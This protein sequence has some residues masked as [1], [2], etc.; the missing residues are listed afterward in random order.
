MSESFLPDRWKEL[1]PLLDAALERE[2]HE[3]PAFL[4][5]AC[6]GDTALRVELETLIA[7]CA[8]ADRLFASGAVERFAALLAEP[9][10]GLPKI[11]ADRYRVGREIGGGGMATVYL[12]R[13]LKHDRDVALKVLR[14]DISAVI[15]AER[16]LAE[17]RITAKLD[18]PHIL[19]LI[20]SGEADGMLF[21]TLPYVRGESLRAKLER[22][23]QLSIEDAVSIARQVASALD[24]AHAQGVVHRD[25]KP[26]NILLHEGVAM[27]ADFGIALAVEEAGGSRLT[28]TGLSLGTPQYMSPEQATGDRALDGRSDIYSLAAV[29]YEMIAGEPPVT[30]ATKQ[31]IIAK[32]LTEPPTKLRVIRSAVPE[33]VDLAVAKALSKV[34]ADRFATAGAFAHALDAA[35]TAT[36]AAPARRW[37]KRPMLAAVGVAAG[38]AVVALA[39]SY[40]HGTIGRGPRGGVTL[41]ARRQITFNGQVAIPAISGD[42]KTLAYRTTNCGPSGCTFGIELQDVVGAASQRLFDGASNI[43]SIEWSPDRRNFLFAGTINPRF[44]T[45][46]IS[47]LG[48]TPRR[49][50]SGSTFFA[51]GDSLLSVRGPGAAKNTN[52]VLVSGLD[53]VPRDSILVVTD[54]AVALKFVRA[55]P[56]SKWIVLGMY[57]RTLLEPR[58]I[59]RDGRVASRVLVG[60]VGSIPQV[61]VS[62][63]AL[64]VSPGGP[65]YPKRVVLRVAL[66]AA[67][68]QLSSTVD[69]LYTGVHTDFGVTADGAALV[70]DEGSAAFDLWGLELSEALHGVF[71]EQK[72]LVHSTSEIYVRLSPDGGRVVVGHDAG[73]AADGLLSWFTIPFGGRV[74]TPLV[75]AGKTTET[76]WSDNSTVA[77]RDRIPGPGARLA[78]SDVA[79]GAVRDPLVVPD[80][81]PRTYSHLSSG[82]WVWVSANMPELSVQFRGEAAPRR[83]RLP[84]W[85]RDA[86]DID[87]ARD[88]RHVAF[89]GWS[90]PYQDSTGVSVMSLADST[91]TP[92]FT[93]FAEGGEV[94]WLRD[95]TL[96][97]RLW[98]GPGTY[99]LYRLL[100]PGRSEKLGTIPRTV[101]SLSIS[102]DLKRAAVVVRNYLGDA[103]MSRVV[104]RR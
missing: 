83:I 70:L 65:Q 31:A 71:P 14:G 2:P 33:G 90:A 54:S 27:L 5:R 10:R 64:W 20:D 41:A 29:L 102:D 93:A 96:L 44:G 6:A 39:T 30:G 61:H 89:S 32:L 104:V 18:H 15:G 103:W 88:G 43:L 95:G 57:H 50:S 48:D 1:G 76:F 37:S 100:G 9:P 4:D 21:Y 13:D 28:E 12:A 91:V 11:V 72:R 35:G 67:S 55:V 23:R 42:G 80:K 24:Y 86:I 94:S 77:I 97:V 75:L 69:T 73:A 19:T 40:A 26:E 87:V 38:A 92:W 34:P 101:S 81:F 78:L 84:A 25:I 59:Q 58:V 52:W 16:F 7:E 60:H 8:R 51:G 99:S 53:G 63:D 47:A 68:G 98:D 17:V 82:G 56:G 22:E 45:F 74:E 62:S 66:D 3:R 79:T 85:Y 46:I 36:A 49:V